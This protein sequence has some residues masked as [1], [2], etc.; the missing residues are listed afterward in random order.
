MRRYYPEYCPKCGS[1][2][3]QSRHA[4]VDGIRFCSKKCEM[5][6][7]KDKEATFKRESS[8]ISS[9]VSTTLAWRPDALDNPMHIIADKVGILTDV[10]CPIH[11]PV[12]LEKAINTF[13]Y[14]EAR[15]VHINGDLIDFNSIS[16]HKGEYYARNNSVEKDL[17]AAESVLKLI[18][19][20]FDSVTLCMGNHDMRLVKFFG[21]E[22]SVQR[23]FMMIGSFHNLKIT[24]RSW[25]DIN[26]DIRC[27]HPKQYS[28]IRGQLAQKLAMRWQKHIITG[29]QHH[30]AKTISPCGKWQCVDL[31]CIADI[32][33]QDYVRNEITDH[34]EPCNGFGIVFGNKIMNFDKHTPWELFGINT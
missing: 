31:G 15:H 29:H 13:K 18:C 16:R 7:E 10:H 9:E 3:A 4:L 14:Y 26:D 22:V 12:W 17:D 8:R 11:S 2:I 20:E 1:K 19:K 23:A 5:D 21:G 27:V 6:H 28:R 24:A 32:E 30:S 34:V 25:V 33:L